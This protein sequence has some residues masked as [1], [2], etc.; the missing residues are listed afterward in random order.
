MWLALLVVYLAFFFLNGALAYLHRSR[1]LR[2]EGREPPTYWRYLF[3]GAV[4]NFKD[5]APKPLQVVVGIAAAIGGVFFVAC[6]VALAHDAEFS[7]IPHP[8]FVAVFCFVLAGLGATLL[9]VGWRLIA[10][11]KVSPKDAA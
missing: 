11:K 10:P 2:L 5:E 8:I 1:L 6:C 4:P 7:R 9:Y 3:S